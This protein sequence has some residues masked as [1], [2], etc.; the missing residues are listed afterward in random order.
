MASFDDNVELIANQLLTLLLNKEVKVK[1]RSLIV[2][3]LLYTLDSTDIYSR[4]R[5][6][7]LAVFIDS[8]SPY[9][10]QGRYDIISAEPLEILTRE[11]AHCIDDSIT[12]NGNKES[13]FS[14]VNRAIKHHLQPVSGMKRYPFVAGAIGYFGYNLDREVESMS[15]H[16]GCDPDI[17]DGLVGIYSWAIIVDHLRKETVLVAHPVTDLS[18]VN[19]VLQRVLQSCEKEYVDFSLTSNF[20]SNYSKSEYTR[21]FDKIKRYIRDGDCYQVNLS[22]CFTA[23]HRGDPWRA[24]LSVRRAAAA[25]FSAYMEWRGNAVLSVSPERFITCNPPKVLTS[26][27]KGTIRRGKSTAEDRRLA[28]LLENSDKDRAENLMIVDLMRND[29]SRCCELGSVKVDRLMGLESFNT[30]HHLVSDISGCLASGFD[31]VDLLAACFPGG[32][33]TGAPKIRAMEIIDELEKHNRSVYC[34][35]IGYIGCDGHM[36]MNIAIR[37]MVCSDNKI[38][39]YAG[40]GIVDDSSCESEYME[41]TIKIEKLMN[42]IGDNMCTPSSLSGQISLI[43]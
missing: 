33:I 37:T 27:I 23:G 11:R 2:E 31:G 14:S 9:S 22:Q 40:G 6:L 4:L 10:K 26:P 29:I 21:A 12:V 20:V 30:V 42:A 32:S 19:D 7:N 25:P 34:G 3:P 41:C 1:D 35:S 38:Y 28:S 13:F 18:L 36:D 16:P 24:Y 43:A 17:P 5:G 15:L 39:C 8:A